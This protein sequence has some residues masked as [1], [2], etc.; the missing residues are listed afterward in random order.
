MTQIELKSVSHKR[1]DLNPPRGPKVMD[2]CMYVGN[3]VCMYVWVC[4][5]VCMYVC[6][7][8]LCNYACTY[9]MM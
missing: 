6:M 4:A 3:Y 8:L 5:R 7:N 2:L 9:V 1:R